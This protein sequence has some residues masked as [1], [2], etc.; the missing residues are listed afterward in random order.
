MKSVNRPKQDSVDTAQLR[1]GFNTITV[2]KKTKQNR[3]S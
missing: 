1:Y 3:N 2:V